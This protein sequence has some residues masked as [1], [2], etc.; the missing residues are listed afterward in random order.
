MDSNAS[1]LLILLDHSILHD[2]LEH[3]V[4]TKGWALLW[5]RSYLTNRMQ[6]V[7]CEDSKS[8]Y[9]NVSI[10]VPQGSVLGPLLF[11]N[12]QYI[13]AHPLPDCN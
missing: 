10:G 6:F 2:H 7:I 9:C 1:S 11:C 3:Y 4:G 12:I 13:L 5:F 8:E